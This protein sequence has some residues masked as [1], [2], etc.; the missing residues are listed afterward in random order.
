MTEGNKEN[1]SFVIEIAKKLGIKK[2]NLFKNF[3]KI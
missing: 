1:L 2:N 3:K